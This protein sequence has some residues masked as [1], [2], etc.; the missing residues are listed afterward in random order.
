MRSVRMYAP[1]PSARTMRSK[2]PAGDCSLQAIYPIRQD[3]PAPLI[4]T[5]DLRDL[6]SRIGTATT[7]HG[8]RL[9]VDEAL[10]ITADGALIPVVLGGTGE[11]IHFGRARR[12]ASRGQRRALFAR[13]RGCTFQAARSAAAQSELHHTTEWI[14]GGRT[15]LGSLAVVCGYHNNEAPRQGWQT[16]MIGGIPHWKPPS[17]HD[18]QQ[19]PRRQLPAAPRAHQQVAGC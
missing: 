7:H 18:P 11:I 17:W 4:V 2:R 13:D 1:R 14:K 5:I 15:D 3:W 19:L 16:V 6:E 12:L 8:G 10:R 9:S